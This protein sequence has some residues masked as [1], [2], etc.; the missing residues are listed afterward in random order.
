MLAHFSK[1][2]YIGD[3]LYLLGI[4]CTKLSLL[5]FFLL[6]FK[7]KRWF[8]LACYSMM[9]IVVLYCFLFFFLYAFACNP[10]IKTW[11]SIEYEGRGSCINIVKAQFAVGGINIG[12]DLVMLLLPMPLIF[13][14]QMDRK[15]KISLF[16][17]FAT[18]TL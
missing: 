11:H 16:F 5:T 3:M 14:L 13:S 15:R 6:V 1:L 12:T 4:M 18:G 17:V 8:R 7:I 10:V 9:V 2:L